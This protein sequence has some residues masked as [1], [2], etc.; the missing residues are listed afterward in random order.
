MSLL[1]LIKGSRGPSGFGF[2][3]AAEDVTAGVDLTGKTILITGINSGLG[4]ESGR[5]LSMR[6][7]HI[8][9][10]ARTL[11]KAQEGCANLS[12]PSV[13]RTHVSTGSSQRNSCQQPEN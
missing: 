11:E 5:V 9:G 1:A 7:A 2:A 10:L 8:I 13:V 3:S 6:G 12:G 4:Q